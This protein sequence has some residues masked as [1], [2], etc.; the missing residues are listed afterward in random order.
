M[1]FAGHGF[2]NAIFQAQPL[3]R[4]HSL[5]IVVADT[6]NTMKALRAEASVAYTMRKDILKVYML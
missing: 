2:F 6:H 3:R 5:A 4:A 1:T